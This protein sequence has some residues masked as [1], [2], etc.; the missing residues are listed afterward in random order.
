VRQK[1]V[2]TLPYGVRKRVELEKALAMTP[3]LLL[4]DEPK[5]QKNEDIKEFYPGL[6]QK[7]KRKSYRSVKHYR[8]RKRWLA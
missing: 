8:R 3:A 5:L 1:I 6:S 7:G 4:L 2:G